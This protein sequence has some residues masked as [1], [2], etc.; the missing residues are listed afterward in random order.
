M[1]NESALKGEFVMWLKRQMTLRDLNDSGLGRLVGVKANT[2]GSWVK[3]GTQPRPANVRALATAFGVNV[4]YLYQLLG[5]LSAGD[6]PGPEISPRHRIL[7]EKA[8]RVNEA[9]LPLAE[10]QID[11]ILRHQAPPQ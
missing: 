5:W 7:V 2:A 4:L 1:G 9:E 8:L 3:S 6:V 11:A 10:E